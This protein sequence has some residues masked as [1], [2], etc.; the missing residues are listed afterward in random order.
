MGTDCEVDID[1][2]ESNPCQNSGICND[3]VNEYSCDCAKTG[4]TGTN[5]EVDIDECAV[6]PCLHNSTCTNLINDFSC[7][8]WDG[9]QGKTCSEDIQ[10]CEGLPC[11]NSATCY[12]RSNKTL[13]QTDVVEGL[14]AEIRPHFIE[15]FSYDK[16]AG[17]LCH[18]PSGFTGNGHYRTQGLDN[19]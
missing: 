19:P 18:C 5:C 17:Y 15:G 16:A 2:C 9:F 14:P 7:D 3:G 1:D 6:E 13:Y 4:F 10:E 8:C 12:E 11:Q